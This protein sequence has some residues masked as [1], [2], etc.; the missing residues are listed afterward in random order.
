VPFPNIAETVFV[1]IDD[2]VCGRSGQ[3]QETRDQKE[4]RAGRCGDGLEQDIPLLLRGGFN[5][6][7]PSRR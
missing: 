6:R 1:R 5:V 3:K 4:R 2:G 7:P